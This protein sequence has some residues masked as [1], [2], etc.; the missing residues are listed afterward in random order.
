MGYGRRGEAF[1]AVP[2]RDRV[3][4]RAADRKARCGVVQ[5]G[6]TS[7]G[8]A[9]NPN[10]NGQGQERTTGLDCV[11]WPRARLLGPPS[12]SPSDSEGRSEASR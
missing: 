12:L 4:G 2:E 11:E 8:Q 10:V 6:C 7:A 5:R 3:P 1:P 9:R